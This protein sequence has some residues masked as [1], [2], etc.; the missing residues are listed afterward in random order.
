MSKFIQSASSMQSCPRP[1]GREIAFLGRS[2]AGKSSLINSLLEQNLAKTSSKPGHTRLLNFF[3]DTRRDIVLVDLPGY[4]YAQ[5]S[6]TE[7]A[8][9]RG[10]I[11]DYLMQRK[12]LVGYVLV[13][14]IRRDF[15][16]EEDDLLN[17][18]AQR[19]PLPVL[20]ALT[21][22]DKLNQKERGARMRYF[23]QFS[24]KLMV[25][26]VSNVDEEGLDEF[27]QTLKRTFP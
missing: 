2:N 9:W 23:S 10:F 18:L 24:G 8:T 3:L 16:P 4:G 19:R 27:N 1:Q 12:E 26:P 6:K 7:S 25:C 5:T 17:W 14:D 22:A 13:M 11:E 15:G 20:V 21:K